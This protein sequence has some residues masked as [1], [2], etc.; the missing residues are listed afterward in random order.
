MSNS[1]NFW[2][3]AFKW[4]NEAAA[5]SGRVATRVLLLINGGAAVALL[6]LIGALAGA[7]CFEDRQIQRFGSNLVW[8]TWGLVAA[9]AA[10]SLVYLVN[11]C[12]AGAARTQIAKPGSSFGHWLWPAHV[13][14]FGAI[15]AGV[16]SL[17]MFVLGMFAV[18]DS[19]SLLNC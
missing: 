2:V 3:D 11:Y 4:H 19:L 18:R 13:F 7:E 8:F 14:S 17:A 9:A 5:K 1:N 12:H 10:L 6:G 16:L 15:L